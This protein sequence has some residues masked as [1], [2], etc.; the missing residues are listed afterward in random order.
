MKYVMITPVYNEEKNI[1][2]T[3]KSVL[4][5]TLLPQRWII[6]DDNSSDSTYQ[7]VDSYRKNYE[8]ITLIKAPRNHGQKGQFKGLHARA[9]TPFNF[10]YQFLDESFDFIVKLD[11]D[12]D[13]PSN[14]FCKISD[15]F[16]KYPDVGICGGYCVFYR[17]GKE[18]KEKSA[19]Y[20]VRGAFKSIRM[21]CWEDIG[22]FVDI[23]GFDGLD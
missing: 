1:E 14:Y 2:I 6:V 4:Q 7:I 13:L 9:I 18:Y 8:W 5:Q 17:D 20:H 16:I 15:T 22:G 3:I 19:S 11:G 23:I 12:L 10:A 21:E